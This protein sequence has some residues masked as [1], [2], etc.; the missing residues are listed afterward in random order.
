MIA[1]SAAD[2]GGAILTAQ[3]SVVQMCGLVKDNRANGHGGGIASIGHSSLV[4]CHGAVLLG[5]HAGRSGGCV[6]AAGSST[7]F[8][9]QYSDSSLN[10]NFKFYIHTAIFCYHFN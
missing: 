5:N 10:I 8:G 7:L 2:M 9:E 3:W 4:L 6:Y 1:G